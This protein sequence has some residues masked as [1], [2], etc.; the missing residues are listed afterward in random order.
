MD[1]WEVAKVVLL[2]VVLL[3]HTGFWLACFNRI[4]ATGLARTTIKF[5]EKTFI[6]AWGMILII[7]LLRMWSKVLNWVGHGSV[8]DLWES[9]PSF[10]F[11]A[12]FCLLAAVTLGVPWVVNRLPLHFQSSR[13]SS[14]LTQRWDLNQEIAR[15]TTAGTLTS[16]FARI[17]WNDIDRLELTVKHINFTQ[18]GMAFTGMRIGHVSDFHLTGGMELDFYRFAA[19]KLRSEHP[20][21]IVVSGDLVDYDEFV[22]AMVDLAKE[23]QAPLGTYFVLGNHDRRLSNVP[24][25]RRKLRDTSWVD[26]SAHPVS[27]RV[28]N[29]RILLAGNEWPWFPRRC[30]W[31]Q[32][33]ENEFESD[34]TLRLAVAHT[35]DQFRWAEGLHANL[36]LAGHLHGGQARFPI[37]GPIVAPSWHGSRFACGVFE[38][39]SRMVMHVSR[40]LGGIHPLRFRCLPEVTVLV[41]SNQNVSG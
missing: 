17:P 20:D 29:G 12:V 35:P 2:G 10:G 11:Y 13:L 30:G 14:C 23:W 4:N 33:T 32:S 18:L 8:T 6:L 21:V 27:I 28:G 5:L 26:V 38:F 16:A 3:G 39:P 31:S 22:P 34:W 19:E 15:V 7:A 9:S 24:E 1:F 41:L 37:V 36:M 40:G 25:F